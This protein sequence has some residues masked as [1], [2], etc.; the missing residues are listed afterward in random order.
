MSSCLQTLQQSILQH[1]NETVKNELRLNNELNRVLESCEGKNSKYAF[2][3]SIYG[4]YSILMDTT[5]I[6]CFVADIINLLHVLLFIYTHHKKVISLDRS[7]LI[8]QCNQ[9]WLLKENCQSK[10]IIILL[11]SIAI[12]HN[13]KINDN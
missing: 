11:I 7:K 9:C 4:I 13:S 2:F 6:H 3:N 1:K 12:I 5:I 10:I 8:C